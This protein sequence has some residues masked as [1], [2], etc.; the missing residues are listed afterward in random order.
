VE[1]RSNRVPFVGLTGG[2]GAGK[3]TALSALAELGAATLSTDA[4]V[5]ELLQTD[6]LREALVERLGDEVAPNGEV[7]RSV[8]AE[9]A[10]GDPEH[11]EWLEGLLWP[12]VGER[13]W[14][15]RQEVEGADDPPVAAVVEVP[16]LFEADM[17]GVFDHTVAVVADEQIRE[18]RAGSRG[19]AAVASRSGRQLPQDEKAQ[20]AD[21]VVR[22]D[23]SPDELKQSLSRFLGTIGTQ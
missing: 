12:K 11:R 2:L 21:F 8:V 15:W 23:G 22:N 19:H 6:E 13:V 3:S 16:L 7:D 1:A 5:H 10:F 14:S 4:V 20:R 18:E 17:E 9:R